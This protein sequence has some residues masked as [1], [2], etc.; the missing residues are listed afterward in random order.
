MSEVQ[1]CLLA[2]MRAAG[3]V[4][5]ALA[6]L[7]A[8]PAELDRA[9]QDC[10]K[11]ET[12]IIVDDYRRAFGRELGIEPE[13]GIED[14]SLYVGS[15]RYRFATSLWP[16]FDLLVREHPNGYTWGPEFVRARGAPAPAPARVTDLAPW[17]TT[18]REVQEHF[19]A[20]ASEVA[21][22]YGKDALR[23]D[24]DGAVTLEFDFGLL[25]AVRTSTVER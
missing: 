4:A 22:D 15:L 3:Q 13:P 8:D 6:R 2:R 9:R 25:Q 19:G 12:P 18:D 11:G 5:A 20:H 23:T 24:G 16:G 17:S 1:L 21:W 10:W 7:G 14:G